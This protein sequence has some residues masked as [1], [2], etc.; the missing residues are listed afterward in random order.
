MKDRKEP[1]IPLY[2]YN[3]L[4]KEKQKFE[5]I[6]AEGWVRMY[7]CGPTVYS[8]QHV[9]NLSAAVF[10]DT[11]RKTLEYNGMK[12][13]QVI[14]ITDFGHLVSD[15][16][17]GEDKMTKG[18]RQ[19]GLPIT[20]ENMKVLAEKYTKVYL[21]DIEKLNIPV[22]KITFPRASEYIAAQI[23]MIQT[24]EEKGYAYRAPDGVYYDTSKF[25]DYGKLGDIDLSSL[26]EGAR[27]AS[28][29]GKHNPTD[30]LLW[31]SDPSFGWNSPWGMGFPGWHIECS[32]M[33]RSIL[34]EQIDIHTGGIEHIPVHHNNEIAQAE[35]AT[36]KKPFSRFWMH[37]NHIQM[38][39]NKISKSLGNTYYLSDL[40]AKGYHPLSLRYLFL[41]AHY[42]TSLNFTWDALT[43]AETALLRLYHIVS[44]SPEDGEV[45]REYQRRFHE[46]INDDLD[47]PG[48]L[49]VIWEMVK[50]SALSPADVRAGILDADRV[51]GFR[52]ATENESLRAAYRA[53][54]GEPV[55]VADLPEEVQLLL[56]ERED[57]RADKN[58]ARADEIRDQ[59][60]EMGYRIKDES[61]GVQVM[62]I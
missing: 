7:N 49:G 17:E 34:G 25:A 59:I 23:A 24:L 14:N 13:R 58:W 20:M 39:G 12:V 8:T 47:T 41:G 29:E 10:A 62:K 53:R 32:A 15:D 43:A 44:T 6:L 26:R 60:A 5:S 16:D 45:P 57:A 28:R 30:F 37:R 48:A 3:T 36:G 54:Y 19:E 11:L 52:F 46:R 35:A 9:G 27:V 33:I 56:K 51:L 2:L 21:E 50:D 55:S 18:L 22:G 31:K 4:G 38:E 61:T 40:I 42:R 1:E